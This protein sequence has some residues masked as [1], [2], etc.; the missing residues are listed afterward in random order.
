MTSAEP[1]CVPRDAPSGREF[2][3]GRGAPSFGARLAII[4]LAVVG[5]LGLVG[6]ADFMLG[7]DTDWHDVSFVRSDVPMGLI[8]LWALPALLVAARWGDW[9]ER[10]PR[11]DARPRLALGLLCLGVAAVCYSCTFWYS[12]RSMDEVLADFD[13]TIFLHGMTTAPVAP[14]WRPFVPALQ[15]QFRIEAPDNAYWASLYLPVN[16]A[17]RAFFE[18]LGDR[19]LTNPLA[20]ALSLLAIY[21]IARRLWPERRDAAFLAVGLLATSAQF[22]VTAITPFAMTLHLALNLAW[23]WLFLRGGAAGHAGALGVG[24]AAAGLHQVIFHPL[25]VAPFVLQLWL[26]RR[27]RAA[28]AYTL[29]YMA[30]CLFWVTYWSFALPAGA[31]ETAGGEAFGLV[32]F[33]EKSL[34]LIA[35]FDLGRSVV[36]V[37]NL[38]RF[39]TWQSLLALPLAVLGLAVAVRA[40]GVLRAL[41]AGL[42]LTIVAVWIILPM[43]GFGWGYRYLHGLLGSLCLLAAFGWITASERLDAA[44]RRSALA[45]VLAGLAVSAA[46][47]APVRFY[48]A[49]D[50]VY[51]WTRA[52]AAIMRSSAEVVVI[53]DTGLFEARV[54]PRNDPFLRDS[55]KV[56]MLSFLEEK[57]IRLLCRNHSVEVFDRPVGEALGMPVLEVDAHPEML[58]RR[59][60]MQELSCGRR[61]QLGPGA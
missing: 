50:A 44:A 4:W 61:L 31:S 28:A 13:A 16:A 11:A 41:A 15:W 42:A 21:G 24:F 48:Q 55:P 7:A 5:G 58:R 39:L 60:L 25:F 27:W 3:P 2:L 29:A 14:E 26:E 22:L 59:A 32:H 40:H 37:H 45:V 46:V 19:R 6:A 56:M 10:L 18:L 38:F 53:D 33:V 23:L 36:M 47:L 8:S 54:L 17:V 52:H 34:G 49:W 57:Q 12:G 30:I 1:T 35:A 20:A 51:P 9:T 43:Q